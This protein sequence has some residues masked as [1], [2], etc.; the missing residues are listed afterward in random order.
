[1]VS[2]AFRSKLSLGWKLFDQ[3]LDEFSKDRG[4]LVGAALA[5]YMLL[6]MAPMIILAVAMAGLILGEGAARA[7]VTRLITDAMGPTA[8][9]TVNEWVQQASDAGGVASAVG[10]ALIALTASR[11]G[12][13][14]RS[15]LNAA[16]NVEVY[17][18]TGLKLSVKD[19]LQRRF[20]GMLL[21]LASGPVLLGVVISRAVLSGVHEL[22]FANS[23][24]SELAVQATQIGFSFVLAAFVATLVFKLVPDTKVGWKPVIWGGVLTSLLFNIGSFLAGMY[25]GQASVAAAYGAA[26]SA[27]VILLWLSFSAQIFLFGAEFT[28]VYAAHFGRG[29]TAAQERE[30]VK[31]EAAARNPP[32][33]EVTIAEPSPP[34]PPPPPPERQPDVPSEAAPR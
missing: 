13:Q 33:E 9:E 34:L 5:F 10:I 6:S 7:E 14:V 32:A 20:F 1:M 11:L 27:V 31:L 17:V 12:V 3:T 15:A 29:L 23:R 19:Y 22:V 18:A 26:G 16:W 28:Q 8:A 21:V 24:V 25:L 30:R 4:D 2:K